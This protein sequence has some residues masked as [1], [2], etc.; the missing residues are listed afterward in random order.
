MYPFYGPSAE[1]QE[2]YQVEHQEPTPDQK[3]NV[4]YPDGF[5]SRV[6][7]QNEP[8][9]RSGAP[10][11]KG[12]QVPS[13]TS[14]KQEVLHAVSLACHPGGDKDHA[15]IEYGNDDY[16]EPLLFSARYTQNAVTL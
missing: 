12:G 13:E 14:I 7:T 15:A 5:M 1:Y 2:Q 8:C 6:K 11:N 10:D 3:C 16:P 9:F 4:Y